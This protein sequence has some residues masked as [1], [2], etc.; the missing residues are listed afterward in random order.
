MKTLENYIE[1]N[2]GKGLVLEVSL[3]KGTA[4]YNSM[5]Q[6]LD[7]LDKYNNVEIKNSGHELMYLNAVY[8]Q[9]EGASIAVGDPFS[10]SHVLSSISKIVKSY[11][12]K[13]SK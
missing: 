13:Q 5:K 8:G 3:P 1:Q 7:S 6:Y 11:G 9:E 10:A 12:M 4:N 2:P